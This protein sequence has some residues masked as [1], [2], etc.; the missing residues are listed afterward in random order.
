M[1]FKSAVT[2]PR[3]YRA[4][5]VVVTAAL[6]AFLLGSCETTTHAQ[7]GEVL[8]GVIGGVI[9]AQ[10]GEGRGRTAAIIVGT[11]AGAMIG[12]HIGESM[13]ETDRMRTAMVLNDSRSGQSTTWVNPDTGYKYTV[14]P[15]RTYEQSSGPCREFRLDATIGAET[16]QDVYG[17]ACL[18]ADGSWLVR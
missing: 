4:G 15:T 14:T 17:T 11:I 16:N 13:D 9:G 8:G 12:R 1:M 3:A 7:Q 2:G 18:Q 6:S 5:A 10:V